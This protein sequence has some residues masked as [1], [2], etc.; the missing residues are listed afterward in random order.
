[1]PKL[2]GKIMANKKFRLGI[3]VMT[4]VFGITVVDSA[5]GQDTALNGKWRARARVGEYPNDIIEYTFLAGN[6]E[7]LREW[8]PTSHEPFE[9]GTYI[10]NAKGEI[11]LKPTHYFDRREKKWHSKNDFIKEWKSDGYTDAEIKEAFEDEDMFIDRSFVYSILGSTTLEL[12]KG[13]QK[14]TYY[15]Q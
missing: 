12:Y 9:K 14:F 5:F 6:Y 3:M 15:K 13:R 7:I 4:L 8:G 2:G 11:I 10:T 1:L